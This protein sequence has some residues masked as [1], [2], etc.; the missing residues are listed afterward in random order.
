MKLAVIGGG[1]GGYTA[2][3][4]AAQLEVDVTVIEKDKVGGTCLNRGCIPT[5]ALLA[6]AD[7][8]TFVK[9]ASEFGVDIDSAP[10]PNLEKM[11]ERKNSVVEQLRGGIEQLFKNHKI[12]LINSSGRL[13]RESEKLFVETSEGR[14]EYDAVIIA[15]GSEPARLSAFDFDQPT[16]MTSDDALDLTVIPKK[17]LILGGGVVGCEFASIYSRL[18]SEITLV[19][20]MSQLL[21]FEER[22]VAKQLEGAFKKQGIRVLTKTSIDK[23]IGYSEESIKAELSNGEIIEADKLL[24]SIGRKLLSENIGLNE[25]G[26]ELTERGGVVVNER[27]ETSVKGVYSVGDVNGGIMLAHWAAAEG[28]VAAEN[29]C[30]KDT[31]IDKGVVLGCIFTKP[32]I[33]SIGLNSEK[34]KE[35]G[36]E[37]N[38]GRFPFSA[39]GKAYA[40]GE[41]EGSV[42][43]VAD[44][45]TD[46]ILGGQIIGPHASDLIHEIALAVKLGLTSR[47]I[48]ETIHAH[49]TLSEAVL[50]AAESIHGR[51]IH[52]FSS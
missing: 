2:A 36:I 33:A 45:K 42:T 32:E 10:A 14:D 26:V 25:A 23:I 39:N 46:K 49:P 50:E 3:I 1:P 17:L 47:Q 30:G 22:R 21:P 18:G 37:V 41:P 8:L 9:D 5:K 11:I 20:L 40:M 27:M 28:V 6:C 4:R 35:Q 43:I 29:V 52:I 15:T 24:V 48:G 16:V 31:L 19:E 34:A 13:I 44:A 7:A 51:A 12:K 38:I